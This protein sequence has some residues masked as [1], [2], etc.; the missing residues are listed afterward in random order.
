M[1]AP[2]LNRVVRNFKAV[3]TRNKSIE[4]KDLRGQAEIAGTSQDTP[5]RTYN[6]EN[7]S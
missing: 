3:A 7:L 4:L 2:T 5:S 1:S 6:A